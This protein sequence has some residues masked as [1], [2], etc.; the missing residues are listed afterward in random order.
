M[1]YTIQ[2]RPQKQKP[3]IIIVSVAVAVVVLTAAGLLYWHHTART[4]KRVP[5]NTGT[6]ISD[7]NVPHKATNSGTSPSTGTSGSKDEDSDTPG[8]DSNTAAPAA[9]TGQFI[10]NHHPNLSGNPAPNTETSTCTTSPGASC[11]ITF[12]N[13]GTVK[14]LPV[15]KTNANGTTVWTDWSLQDI[16]LTQGTWHTRAVATNGSRQASATDVMDLVVNP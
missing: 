3:T 1:S 12:T 9:P 11:T 8:T 7:P 4:A 16:G 14:S 2:K 6:A 15:Q 13:G 10:S 5:I